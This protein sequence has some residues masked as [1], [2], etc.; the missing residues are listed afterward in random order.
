MQIEMMCLTGRYLPSRRAKAQY[1]ESSLCRSLS[2]NCSPNMRVRE[3][4][5][6][7][8]IRNAALRDRRHLE[9]IRQGHELFLVSVIGMRPLM[10]VF[11]Q[12][13]FYGIHQQV[14]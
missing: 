5:A 6:T 12:P 2:S 10:P 11:Y 9:G 4:S 7:R 3:W 1:L 14:T 8:S 13:S